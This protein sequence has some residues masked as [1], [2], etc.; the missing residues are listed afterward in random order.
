MHTYAPSKEEV[1]RRKPSRQFARFVRGKDA[2]CTFKQLRVL[3]LFA[4]FNGD[5]SCVARRL[6]RHDA[7]VR[8]HLAALRRMGYL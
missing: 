5:V 7:T 1:F 4:E 8:K 2:F 3:E 6:R